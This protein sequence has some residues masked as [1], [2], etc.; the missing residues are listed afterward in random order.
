[1]GANA[2]SQPAPVLAGALM[3]LVLVCA[4]EPVRVMAAPP[5]AHTQAATQINS[6]AAVLNGMGV[7]NREPSVAW[8]QWGLRGAPA[9]STSPVNIGDAPAVS[10]VS[11]AIGG[12]TNGGI[13]E[14]RLVVS[15]A[16][17][18]TYGT[19]QWFTTGARVLAWG[20]NDYNQVSGATNLNDVVAVA[21]DSSHGLAL[22]V[23][24]T[25]SLWGYSAYGLNV[26]PA[27]LSNAV[28]VG[29]A[30][31]Y[32]HSLAV[33][34]DG[35]VVAWGNSSS[36]LTYV[37]TWL[38]NVVAVAAGYSQSLALRADGSVVS[39]GGEPVPAELFDAVS[40]ACGSHH[41]IALTADGQVVG[42]GNNTSGQASA[43]AGLSNVV[44]IAAGDW[45]NLALKTDGTVVA[46]GYNGYGQTNVPAGL[47]NVIAVAA[48]FGHSVA[49][50]ADGSVVIW[51]DN[52]YAQG[53]VP[54]GLT[55]VIALNCGS[56]FN[57]SLAPNQPPQAQGQTVSGPA[58]QDQVIKLGA[59]DL[60]NDLLIF[61]ITSLPVNGTLYQYA[62]GVR[63]PTITATNT[64]VTDAARR[65]IFA[66]ATD[67]YGE[68]YDAFQF[69]ASDGSLTA[70]ATVTVAVVGRPYG[71]TQTP[72]AITPTTARLNGM[73][74]PNAFASVAW[75][76]WGPRGVYS[77]STAVTNVGVGQ[78]VVHV[79]VVI[80][81]LTN[82]GAYQC[83]LVSSN[84]AG[85]TRGAVQFFTTGMRVVGWG[86]GGFGQLA[87]PQ[88]LTNAVAVGGG[89][90]YGIALKSGGAVVTWSSNVDDVATNMPAGL[91]NIVA[92]ATGP[93][94]VVALKSDGTVA[95]W[96]SDP[97]VTNVPA[98]LSNVVSVAAGWGLVMAL[99]AD[100][101]VAGWGNYS[102]FPVGL[103]N[104]VAITSKAG[105][106]LALRVDGTVVAWGNNGYGQTNVPTGL[107]H[108]VALSCGENH[109][110]AVKADGTVV[111]WGSTN[112]SG[113]A[114]LLASLSNVVA[115]ASGSAFSVALREN[116]TAVA[117]G[118]NYYGETNV[119]TGLS[120]SVA[121]AAGYV[122]SYA[123]V[124]NLPP[125]AMAQ[126]VL[127]P[128]NQD[129]VI[130]LRGTDINNDPLAFRITTLPANGV[131]YQSVGGVRGAPITSPNTLVTDPPG[132]VIF[133]PAPNA[134]GDPYTTF[135]YSASDGALSST[136]TVTI[137]VIGRP[138][139]F[140]QPTTRIT[141]TN[142]LLNGM[143]VPNTF[144]STAWFEWGPQG[145]FTQTTAP[146]N[147]GNG[148]RVVRV[149]AP[150]G[151]LAAG[152]VYQCRLVSSNSA[153]ATFGAIHLFTTGRKA[154]AWGYNTNDYYYQYENYGQASVPA[155]ISNVVAVAAGGRHNL[156]LKSDGAVVAW[157]Y[158]NS[159]QTNVP[160]GLG[161]I[162][163]IAAGG[164][165]RSGGG[166]S[167]LAV[168]TN[169]QVAAWGYVQNAASNAPVNLT[170]AISGAVGEYHAVIL[171]ADGTLASWGWNLDGF[172]QTNVPAGLSNVVQVATS[173][174]HV[175]ALKAD[176]SVVAWGRNDYGQTNVPSSLNNVV[177]VATGTFHSLALKRDGTVV[178][179][180][181]GTNNTTYNYEYG[182]SAVPP[183]LSNVVAI[184][185][186][187][188][189]SIALKADG[190]LVGWGLYASIPTNT[191]PGLV[192]IVAL[193]SGSAHNL[194]IGNRMPLAL[195]QTVAG[196][197]N[198]DQVIQLS[199]NDANGD[200]LTLRITALPGTG[201]LY[202][203]NGGMR[204]PAIALNN[205]V[206]DSSGRV[207]FAPA[208]DGFGMPYSSFNFVANDGL[209][210]ST[211]ATVTIN[212]NATPFVFT[213]APTGIR[214]TAATMNGW[215]VPNGLASVAWFEWGSR[216][217]YTE[218]SE[219]VAV[220]SGSSVIRVSGMA[221][222]LV[223]RG[224]Y[225][226][227]FVVS[228]L[229][230]VTRAAPQ[231]FTTGRRAITWG[232]NNYGQTNTPTDLSNAV[233]LARGLYHTLA[234]TA[235]GTVAAWG[236]GSPGGPYTYPHVGQSTPPAGLSNV[237][238]VAGG[239][240]HSLALKADG[241]V[242]G[243]GPNVYGATNS[244]PGLSNVVGIAA[245]NYYNLALRADGTVFAWG[246]NEDG[247]TN[248]PPGLSNVVAIAAGGTD[249]FALKADG[250]IAAWGEDSAASVPADLK[251]VVSISA[252]S[253]N[254]TFSAR[255]A[256]KR[257]GRVVSWGWANDQFRSPGGLYDVVA[258]DCTATYEY[259]AGIALFGDGALAVW[260]GGANAQSNMPVGLTNIVA[261]CRGAQHSAVIGNLPPTALPLAVVGAPNQDLTIQLQG[262]DPNGDVLSYRVLSLPAKGMLYQNNA[263][264][265]GPVISSPNTAVTDAAGRVIFVPPPDEFGRPYTT[266]DFLANDDPSDSA[267]ATVTIH[268]DG[269]PHAY[270][271]S[272]L[273]IRSSSAT[274][275]G[276]AMP[277]N[278]ASQAWLEW[279]ELGA[280]TA[281]HEL[282]HVG[283]GN[284]VVPV[285]GVVGNLAV[286][287]D[288]QF[289]LVVSNAAGTTYGAPQFFTTG[290]KPSSWGL[291][292]PWGLTNAV[293]ISAG[294][295]HAMAQRADG[296]LTA[297]GNNFYGQTNIPP[298]LSNV[299]ALECG[300]Y[301]NLA[302]KGDGSLV[303]W[304]RNDF[305]QTN[306]PVGLS[307]LFA[308]AGG[309]YHNTFLKWDGTVGAWGDNAKGQTNA[310]PGLSNVV[311]IAAG[312]SHSLALKSDGTVVAWGAGMTNAGGSFDYGQSIVPAGLSN[313]VAIA[314][315][316][317]HSLA[318]RSDG[319]VA[320]W[321]DT[322]SSQTRVPVGLTNVVAIAGGSAHS[323]A[324]RADG[325][326]AVWDSQFYSLP[327]GWSNAVAI[328]AG[329]PSL[330]L[331]PN[332]PPVASPRTVSGMANQ[333]ILIQLTS[334]DPDYDAL[335]YRIVSLPTVGSL[336]QAVGTNRGAG[337]NTTN[338]YI[339]SS[340]TVIYAP[341]TNGLG[342]PLATFEYLADDSMAISAPATV[343]VTITSTV[344]AAT[345]PAGPIAT[346]RAT[347]NGMILA[348][349]LPT[350]VWFEWGTN[351]TYGQTTVPSIAYGYGSV[352]HVAQ[353]LTGLA[354]ASAYQFR[355]V[356]SNAAG[357][358]TGAGQTFGTGLRL[359]TWGR[360]YSNLL[361]IPA[362]LNAVKVA[363]GGTHSLALRTDGSVAAWGA[364]DSYYPNV[365]NV[366]TN[367]RASAVA[368]GDYHSVALRTNGSVAAW[369]GY[370]YNGGAET[371]VPAG[372]S[373]VVAIAAGGSH[374]L[375][376][377][378]NGTVVAWGVNTYLQT[379]V[380]TGLS[381]VIAVAAG[382]SH[383]LALKLDR[384]LA[385]W[386]NNSSGQRTIPAGLTN[387]IAIAAGQTHSLA[388][389]ANGT[390]FAWGSNNFGQTNVP[391]GLSNVVQI[392]CNG[393]F[394]A[395]LRAEGTL[396]LWGNNSYG[397]TNKPAALS[398]LVDVACGPTH[399]LTLG[400]NLSPAITN[401]S[402]TGYPNQ[403]TLVTLTGG[404]L[405][406]D[407]LGFRVV[408][409]PAT[410]SLHQFSAGGRGAPIT[411]PGTFVADSAGR[412]F[413]APQP[414]QA[415]SPYSSFNVQATDGVANS[416][417]ALVTLNILVPPAPQLSAA[418]SGVTPLATPSVSAAASG[419]G[420]AGTFTL[421]FGGYSNLAYQVWASTNLVDWMP[422][423]A[424]VASSNG[425]YDFVDAD[426]PNW[427]YRF[428]RIS[429][430]SDHAFN[431]VFS[432]HSNAT[433]R[434]WASTNLL[435]WE[436]LGSA[437]AI[438]NGWFKFMDFD[439]AAFPH[440]FYKAGA[441]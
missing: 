236:A 176:G 136:A 18:V 326:L 262:S 123:L 232:N 253:M 189:Y 248:V 383:S 342:N 141:P 275:V 401:K 301:H 439:A 370:I 231:I 218:A 242:V 153:G 211:T 244:P 239:A 222:N 180:G 154:V 388:L 152:G 335:R 16:A 373:N 250:T 32:S 166:E 43:P 392:A 273:A 168:K 35:R 441:P 317:Y 226:C 289:R 126:S 353:P 432:G 269:R 382:G 86:N 138:F 199:G 66:P 428:Y 312:V 186:D 174:D 404:D 144:A 203:F 251:D 296:S 60:N 149:S 83:R 361:V 39:W 97:A 58:N 94:F 261:V 160:A 363:G 21:A 282:I 390:V 102:T 64:P 91:S 344:A 198:A 23:D 120:N 377:R 105:H 179:W 6:N 280:F 324:L 80:T 408:S 252:A 279:G 10:R 134:F 40:I 431:V 395:A 440:R 398:N 333:D 293:A 45:H 148:S 110:V 167:S 150:V 329:G 96:G 93:A 73:V 24:G 393:N 3:L 221:S 19:R 347:L 367:L 71:F 256:I 92:V 132:R 307:N 159:N 407:P 200:S 400:G 14:C 266:F 286:G 359:T 413:F 302:L 175:L 421:T 297:W 74:A 422:L 321:G 341:P 119:P 46:W 336:Y 87:I 411:A 107:E 415:G 115:V 197:A 99:K 41:S 31:G 378:A 131:L 386:G 34:A 389:R 416:T 161:G 257:D 88:G 178:A 230:G 29:M 358:A 133:A 384:T 259:P 376:L 208:P 72:D 114:E 77:Q 2:K 56:D 124:P 241:T 268:M 235:E 309:R 345:L 54:D 315:G 162:E 101:T 139:G 190:T 143:T 366:P 295:N 238:A 47:S 68:P 79:S 220:G 28:V 435:D 51:G 75:F 403:D 348:G 343:S 151:G 172:S 374:T 223:A 320:A 184:A 283:A 274:L 182:Q 142:A 13:Y 108:V 213:A 27:G 319:T 1:M 50:K 433:Y 294:L 90:N 122:Q 322:N 438:S 205:V 304:G 362:G 219:P 111:G 330:V 258:A 360:S 380:P 355:L 287:G 164:T 267:P 323:L 204:G 117:W 351:G 171:K 285:T 311:A 127:G 61:R 316:S 52:Q 4:A 30:A 233:S 206:S 183:G 207:I 95:T 112:V 5:Y 414:N 8:F 365:V 270:T 247:Q 265:R 243:W 228:N 327:S 372:L 7:A 53:G 331:R 291:A 38:S 426:M 170:N 55:E 215:V 356:A 364:G 391:T 210:D 381:N 340:Y 379:N 429:Q 255:V 89:Y 288:Y 436:P 25:L 306:V 339:T 158:N 310:P 300:E 434:V 245:G 209:V 427:P 318:L 169:G 237:V 67:G 224:I 128:A 165:S 36:S 402:V 177:Q 346:D 397:Q 352:T 385:G 121:V 308:A 216:G 246:N 65:V 328:A 157:G 263:G 437:S 292:A 181:A 104:I 188:V 410:G 109:S 278:L 69:S 396:T 12:L 202:Q 145:A 100:G 264:A 49:L 125:Q 272:P 332:L 26:L 314:A 357:V 325:S 196:L 418:Q 70:T 229:V 417:N 37:P 281:T 191:P 423:G 185:A 419:A 195:S 412:F 81:G 212:V 201:A 298:G 249:A 338:T 15:N 425:W 76:E 57:L 155:G 240:L 409:L 303:A 299:V 405:N 98:G 254:S 156:V 406:G 135:I 63:G 375:A 146:V 369:G 20:R 140:T 349:G 424:A 118:N 334:L 84:A 130:T 276:M 82:G 337:I 62:G 214:S 11:V 137:A 420:P 394:N 305:G 48:G 17:G 116:G 78:P 163:M 129:Q 42:W 106:S 290:R 354:P 33:K 147:V 187:T 103:S 217:G 113:Q 193:A 260:G 227:R 9:Q 368:A 387:V 399:V 234:V 22:R 173:A 430:P 225:Q 313:I 192:G 59:S 85:L 44:A 284:S 271:A 350:S 371:N 277:H 194:V